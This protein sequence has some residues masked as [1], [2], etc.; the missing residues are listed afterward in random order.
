MTHGFRDTTALVTGAQGF[1]GCWLAERLL[2]EGARV[3]TPIRDVEPKTRFRFD[4]IYRRCEV[5]H[6]DV[7]DYEALVSAL[8]GH[9]VTAVFHLAAQPLVGFANR[10]PHSTWE[11]NIRGTY[12][13]LEACRAAANAGSSVER[14]VV[15]SSDH[16]YGSHDELPYREDYSFE[17]IYPYD[18]SKACAD[19]IARCYAD[20]YELPIAVS[21]M[22]NT[23]GGGDLNWSR[24]VPDTARALVE[25]ARPVIRSDGTPER[26]YLYVEDAVD[27]Y[28]AIARSLDDPALRGRA[29]NVGLGQGVSALELVQTMI[30]VSGREIEPEIRGAAPPGGEIDCQYVD[31]TAI[32]EVLGWTP[33]FDVERGLEATYRWYEGYLG[34]EDV[35]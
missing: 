8:T 17:A 4:G 7:V 13:M 6:A 34:K 30:R 18:V 27:A 29:W 15:A 11:S 1:I 2:A 32:R 24:I 20:S 26:D 35:A 10:S 9:E 14:I 33:R 25:G 31:P 23:Y 21:R 5:I 22:A 3:V 16:A 19:L 12:T 28:L